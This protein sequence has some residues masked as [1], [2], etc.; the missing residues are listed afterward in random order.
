V[1]ELELVAPPGAQLA[2]LAATLGAR[3]AAKEGAE[4]ELE[5]RFYDT[6]DGRLRRAGL[7]LAH[8]R[9]AGAGG[10]PGRLVLC[11][12]PGSEV[13]MA[14]ADQAVAGGAGVAAGADPG[15]GAAGLAVV[16]AVAPQGPMFARDLPAGRLRD[17][18]ATV[19]SPRALLGLAE[20]RAHVLE[21][22]LRDRLEKTI[23]RGALVSAQPAG[24][25]P[26]SPAAAL[27]L[28]LHLR[29]L[30]GYEA[31]LVA[32]RGSLEAL[33]LTAAGEP[34][35]DEAARAAGRAPEGVSSAI[36]VALLATQRSDAAAVA[37]LRRLGEVVQA[38]RA[39]AIAALDPEFLHDLRV[40]LR[41]TRTVLKQLRGVF[42]PQALA[43]FREEFRWLAG[44]TSAARDL[45]V[46]LAEWE[47]LAA[48]AGE[49]WRADLEPVAEVLAR[50]R[51][52]A[53]RAC[54]RALGGERARRLA[55][56]F[57]ELLDGLVAQD[58]SRRPDA[59]RAIGA[60]AGE[61]IRSV[62]G[63]MRRRGG[64][65]TLSSPATDYH[66]LRKQGKELRYLLELF[67]RPLFGADAVREPIG[68]LK[69]LQDVLGRH[70]DREAQ[71]ALLASLAGELAR[72]PGGP[73]ALMACGVLIE[74][75]H[76]DELAARREFAERFAPFA[77]GRIRALIREGLR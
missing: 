23:A 46:Q 16:P 74:R 56:E 2:R 9:E 18:L 69:D 41:R 22:S 70:Q 3:V 7:V 32:L 30:R 55:F 28:R 75:L 11:A 51:E 76:E 61:R 71:I 47:A 17:R 10:S 29:A 4:R 77:G 45:E 36:S 65:I 42:D 44:Q 25:S 39:G 14:A 35:V 33:S 24:Q 27:R 53:L 73:A 26:G 64:Q 72:M 8:V 15:A 50:R 63:R 68:V 66:E 49:R 38:N 1:S 58:E 67:G 60:L 48:L 40:A 43:H 59:A 34:L 37:V 13:L 52:L 6:F 19:S 21:L 62:Y 31:E 5:L 57:G 20:V 54:G 12:R